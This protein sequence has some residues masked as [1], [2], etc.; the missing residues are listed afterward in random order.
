LR[1]GSF[2]HRNLVNKD[3]S[4]NQFLVGDPVKAK[5]TDGKWY[6][7][8]IA[9]ERNEPIYI[10]DWDDKD[11][12][13]RYK[14][15]SEIQSKGGMGVGA[16]VKAHYHDGKMYKATISEIV[17][18]T[19][20]LINW[21]DGSGKDRVKLSSFLKP[22]GGLSDPIC[23]VI[24]STPGR[25]EKQLGKTEFIMNDL[26][27]TFKKTIAMKVLPDEEQTL[28]F[29]VY[30][31]DAQNGTTVCPPLPHRPQLSLRTSLLLL[32]MR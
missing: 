25:G 8:T 7:A 14:V 5:Y 16:R 22:N 19:S 20:Y 6:P 15:A 32:A 3:A 18:E 12:K 10:I 24:G 21:T 11:P 31:V 30:D 9:E 26:N 2:D 13:D 1:A 27:P 23:I 17:E 28:T 29:K 4:G